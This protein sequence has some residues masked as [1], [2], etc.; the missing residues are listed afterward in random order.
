MDPVGQ[1]FRLDALNDLSQQTVVTWNESGLVH[2]VI[3]VTE[4]G[5]TASLADHDARVAAAVAIAMAPRPTAL[6]S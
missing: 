1:V 6:P 4:V 2:V 5:P 3:V